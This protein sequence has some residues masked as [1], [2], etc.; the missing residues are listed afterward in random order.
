MIRRAICVSFFLGAVSWVLPA[1]SSDAVTFPIDKIPPAF[2]RMDASN[3]KNDSIIKYSDPTYLKLKAALAKER[4]GW[5]YKDPY[6]AYADWDFDYAADSSTMYIYCKKDVVSAYI[7]LDE[8]DPAYRPFADKFDLWNLKT[9][10]VKSTNIDAVDG[11]TGSRDL[12]YMTPNK[13]LWGDM[14][15]IGTHSYPVGRGH[16]TRRGL[17]MLVKKSPCSDI[18]PTGDH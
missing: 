7:D 3:R 12:S 5:K 15:I 8:T 10:H 11:G 13:K 17:L 6:P 4:D 2:L 14:K 1:S 9:A 18:L 16:E